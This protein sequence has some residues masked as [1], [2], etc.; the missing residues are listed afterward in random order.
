MTVEQYKRIWGSRSSFA[1]RH[2]TTSKNNPKPN[3]YKQKEILE[4][5]YYSSNAQK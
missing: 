3:P 5:N 2:T 1:Q 4:K